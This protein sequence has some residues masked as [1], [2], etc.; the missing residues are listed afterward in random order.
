MIG[1]FMRWLRSRRSRVLAKAAPPP[2]REFVYL[3]EVSVTSLLSSRLGALPSEFTE[4][5]SSSMKSELS[6]GISADAK[7]LKSNVGSRF[8]ATQS[9]DSQVL[10]KATVQATFKDLYEKQSDSLV[11]KPES[12]A[13]VPPDWSQ[14][15]TA[16]AEDRLE[17]IAKY[18]IISESR[19]TRGGLFEAE[20]ELRADPTF[21]VNSII[22]TLADL[23]SDPS[24]A[25]QVNQADMDEALAMNRIIET[26]MAGLVP[27]KCKF[28]DYAVYLIDGEQYVI[29]Q[30][31]TAGLPESIRLTEK[32]FYLVGVVEQALFWKD[33]RRVL[34][35]DARV[36]V[37]CRVGV[38][39]IRNEWTPVKLVDVLK[40]VMPELANDIARFSA[41]AL[42]AMTVESAPEELV[43]QRIRVL[44]LYGELITGRCGVSLDDETRTRIETLAREN[45]GLLVSITDSRTAFRL[46]TQEIESRFS[47]Q[48]APEL[49]V[50]VRGLA[51][52]YLGASPGGSITLH[53]S[54]N[55]EPSEP[56]AVEE[57]FLD[58]E[59]VAI[60]W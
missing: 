39:G 3:D 21:H 16:R 9:R 17:S 54:A 4:T 6:S 31:A 13:G 29:H 22:S 33:M 34:F 36:R 5:L 2:L 28:L 55:S 27:L 19:F 18:W 41:G 14:I 51:W 48:V 38:T 60:Y 58:S 15:S 40:G 30:K 26:L 44:T 53:T 59:I 35:S 25:G 37:L 43:D 10:R 1:R 46:I 8:E 42:Q 24:V 7:I 50:Q 52:Q 11:I 57:K 45:S 20:V 32:P 47:V 49:A 23:I 12:S 56:L